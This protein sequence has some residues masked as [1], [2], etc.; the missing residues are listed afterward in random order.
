MDDEDIALDI[1][2]DA[3]NESSTEVLE[4]SLL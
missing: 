3:C 1:H 2:D 4:T